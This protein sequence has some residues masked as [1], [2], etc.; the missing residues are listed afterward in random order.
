M[1]QF[2]SIKITFCNF[3]S[4]QLVI[5]AYSFIIILPYMDLKVNNL[6][7]CN[8]DECRPPKLLPFLLIRV[9]I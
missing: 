5:L 3:H 4:V 6:I 1:I 9:Q 2:K 8:N 7:F